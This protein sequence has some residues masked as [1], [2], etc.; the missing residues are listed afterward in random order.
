MLPL[1]FTG[2]ESDRLNPGAASAHKSL[3]S[4]GFAA[5]DSLTLCHLNVSNEVVSEEYSA[6]EKHVQTISS[7]KSKIEQ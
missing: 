3:Y 1:S 2:R 6:R 4:G 5:Q 7:A